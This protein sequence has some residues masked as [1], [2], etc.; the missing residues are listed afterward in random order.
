MTTQL[1]EWKDTTLSVLCRMS[2][3]GVLHYENLLRDKSNE[4][5][6][7]MKYLNLAVDEQRLRCTL[8]H[9]YTTFKRNKASSAHQYTAV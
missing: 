5:R 8:K 7:L 9:D 6:K 2:G 1:K 4:L 3:G